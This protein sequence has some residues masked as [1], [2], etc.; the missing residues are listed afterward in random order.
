MSVFELSV[1]YIV[2]AKE[3]EEGEE[4]KERETEAQYVTGCRLWQIQGLTFSQIVYGL[5]FTW[6]TE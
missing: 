6:L 3:E 4:G 2:R 1:I 5:W